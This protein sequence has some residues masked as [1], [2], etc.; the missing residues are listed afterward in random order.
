MQLPIGNRGM[1]F[2]KGGRVNMSER[3][4]WSEYVEDPDVGSVA[5]RFLA[6]IKLSMNHLRAYLEGSGGASVTLELTAKTDGGEERI[7][8]ELKIDVGHTDLT[9]ITKDMVLEEGERVV[10]EVTAASGNPSALWIGICAE[11]I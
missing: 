8:R 4:V 5:L 10:A 2:G 7:L 1:R 3:N 9:S 11:V 6:A